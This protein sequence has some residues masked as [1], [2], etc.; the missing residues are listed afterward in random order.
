[1]ACIMS[2]IK[3]PCNWTVVDMNC[4]LYDGD[5]LYR[6]IDAGQDLLLPSDL[7]MCVHKEGKI[8]YIARGKEAV[9]SL[10]INPKRTETILYT[11]CNYVHSIQTS[12]IIC[13]GDQRG[14]SAIAV[15]SLDT[16]M[17]IF[18]SH[19]RDQFGM[20]HPNGT[21]VLMKFD[22]VEDTVHIYVNWPINYQQN[23]FT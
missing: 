1:M 3:D 18:D 2:K 8:F 22:N 5:K 14:S 23:C 21:A 16:C 17:Y 9:G 10:S 4:I 11:L 7:P 12:A 15:L 13:L 19:S 6:T 20:P